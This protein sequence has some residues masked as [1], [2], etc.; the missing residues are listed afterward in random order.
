ML[1]I[2]LLIIFIIF[3]LFLIFFNYGFDKYPL[4]YVKSEFDNL[5][6]LVRDMADKKDASDVLAR[7]KIN[8]D[9]LIDHLKTKYKDND[10]IKRLV[11]K[12]N[13]ENI[14]ETDMNDSSTSYSINKGSELSICIRDKNDKNFKI[15]DL[16]TIMFV[17]IHE[18]SHIM[19]K[20]YGHNEEFGDNF[21][22]LLKESIESGIYQNE[23][24]SLNNKNYCG[25]KITSNPLI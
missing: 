12:F 18:L 19:S 1:F 20:S 9:K 7:I 16:N 21:V 13:D 14:R 5:E 4:V 2:K 24:Y 22:F 25:I 10:N 8:I 15:H 11:K 17:V 6:H 23:D 3:L